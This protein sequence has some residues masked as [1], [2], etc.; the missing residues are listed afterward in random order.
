M[1]YADW[2]A[3]NAQALITGAVGG[4]R[5][6]RLVVKFR[7]F[8]V[9]S[10]QQLGEGLQFAG[11]TGE[12]AADGA[13]GGRPVYSRITGEGGYFDSRVV[14]VSESGPKDDRAEAAGDDGLRRRQRAVPDRQLDHRAG[15]ALLARR[16]TGCSTPATRP[17]SRGST[18][19][20]VATRRRSRLLTDR[21]GDDD[22][23]AA[24]LAR[25]ADGGLFA[26]QQGGNTDI[27]DAGHRQRAS[28]AG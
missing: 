1:Q 10:G 14:F 16:A 19:L 13:Q 23:R 9:F 15:A 17:A 11:S 6:A 12:L 4:R 3:I 8:D 18:M 7:L 28:A 26:A 24:L 2:K 20:D 22:L 25:W 5:A 27:Y 21:P